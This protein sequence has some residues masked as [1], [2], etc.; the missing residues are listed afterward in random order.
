MFLPYNGSGH[1]CYANSL[2]MALGPDSPGPAFIEVLTG[3]PFG[4]QLFDGN[5]PFFDP[6]GWDGDI[7]LD[8]A[9]AALGWECVRESGGTP[10]AAA[11]RLRAAGPAD[12]LLVGPVEMGLLTHAPNRGTPFGADHFVVVLGVEGGLVRFHDPAGF[13]FATVPVGQFLEAWR[14][15]TLLYG[16][17]YTS[18]R[19]FVRVREAAAVEAVRASA[20]AWTAWL[21]GEHGFPVTEGTLANRE[22]AERLAAM[23]EKGLDEGMRNQLVQFAVQ[24]GARRLNDAGACLAAAGADEA[25]AIAARQARLVGGLQYDLV[26]GRAAGAAAALRE[27]GPTYEALSLELAEI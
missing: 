21:R 20:P 3:S 5:T 27:L 17:S 22:A 23:V 15:D 11:D 19:G 24:V 12:P 13:P 25:S 1:Y 10:E 26:N 8:A 2:S 4:M 14:T 16:E 7:G 6:A 9:C 18:R